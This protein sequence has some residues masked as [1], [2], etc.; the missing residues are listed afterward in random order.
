MSDDEINIDF[1][2]IKSFFK[3]KKNKSRNS[4]D[5]E[6]TKDDEITLDFSKITNLFKT[7]DSD[8]K[9]FDWKSFK[10]AFDFISKYR[11]VFLIL[12]PLL[13][14][15]ML[16]AQPA[17]LPL[18][19]DWAQTTVYNYHKN[20]IR[21]QIEKNYPTLPAERKQVIVDEQFE[22][23]LKQQKPAVDA[24]IN[25]LSNQFKDQMRD[26]N[27][28]TYL[29]AIDPYYW[30][31]FVENMEE[32]GH[33]GDKLVD[34]KP[35]DTHFL[36]PKGRFIGGDD[37]H[38]KFEY[39]T[40]K[41]LNFF[42]R[43][44]YPLKVAFY[45]PLILASLCVIPA[46]FIAK[47]IGGNIAGFFAAMFVAIHPAFLTRTVAGFAD[48]DAYNVLFPL[49]ITWVFLEAFDTKKHKKTLVLGVLTGLLVGLYS[50][51]WGGWWY[52]FD[53]LLAASGVFLVYYILIHLKTIHTKKTKKV[54]FDAVLLIGIFILSTLVFTSLTTSL[55]NFKR[56]YSAPLSFIQIKDVA[57]TT[58]WPNVY[59]TV[60]EQ[61]EITIKGAVSQ[62]GGNL[63]FLMSLAGI[64]LTLMKK[65]K[66]G[67]MDIRYAVL[68]GIWFLAT[69]YASTKGI[70]Y[71]MLL[72]PAFSIAF[73]IFVGVVIRYLGKFMSK[74][75]DIHKNIAKI[76]LIILFALLLITPFNR[77]VKTAKNELPSMNDAWVSALEEIKMNSNETAIINSWW[78][79]GHWFK[80]WADRPVTFDGTSQTGPRA[81]WIGKV[82]LTDNETQA[83]GILRMLDC[84]GNDAF[85]KI[86]E[87]LNE[88]DSIDFVNE[89]I[90]VDK[91]EAESILLEQFSVKQTQ[92]ILELT[93]CKPPENFF[94]ASEDMV[95]KS[96]VWAHFGSWDFER[97]SMVYK[98]K[99][100]KLA[101]GKQILMQE[102]NLSDQQADEYYYQIQTQDPNSWIAPWPSY[103]SQ[104]ADCKRQDDLVTCANG[105]NLNLTSREAYVQTPQGRIRP[106]KFSYIDQWGMFRERTHTK[107]V[108]RTEDGKIIS[109][110]FFR[111][112]SKYQ[113]VLM[114][115]SL[116]SS[117]FTRLFF[118]QGIGLD[119]FDRFH[120][121]TDLQGLDIYVFEVDWQGD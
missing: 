74:E 9:V 77:A 52:I 34:G 62:I 88:L 93:H 54:I 6:K 90:L 64:A 78:D 116:T 83:I 76:S 30:L 67:K 28:Q 65:D 8:E 40:Y 117:M 42:D 39:Y 41:F 38:I 50:S 103:Y 105:L 15:V 7:K 20:T 113:S 29:L 98:V 72:V 63:V 97:A 95:A 100:T 45:V 120:G 108:W 35:F 58:I 91:K 112:G 89:L 70:R 47:K 27:G 101:E 21:S 37:F 118:F 14:S 86:N 60:A 84:G 104:P 26:E 51:A 106:A 11:V 107:N 69:L 94:I 121:E 56:V 87:H 4:D 18:T 46:F 57:K 16:R 43:E 31:R 75:L 68:L 36:A 80:Y 5:S 110:A 25:E 1:G 79:F 22:I 71:V 32:N 109:A 19:D 61:N 99:P 55:G 3:P 73:G 53:F 24:Q 119:H 17:F 102:F 82:L 12:I 111:K 2:K 10:P 66:H 114:D 49:L 115:S 33:Y 13:F 23:M 59:T 96:G 92:E 44:M 85:Y 48:T 81:H